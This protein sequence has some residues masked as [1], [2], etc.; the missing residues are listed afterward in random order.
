MGFGFI[1][2]VKADR[3]IATGSAKRVE[4]VWVA[5]VV[6]VHIFH[7]SN[8]SQTGRSARIILIFF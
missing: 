6:V 4:E 3:E 8:L 2:F 5:A 7:V 1:L